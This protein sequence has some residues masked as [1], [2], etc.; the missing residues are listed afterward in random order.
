ML[1]AEYTKQ[2]KKD[3]KLA[4]KRNLPED[5]I[6]RVMSK[7]IKEEPLEPRYR[8]HVLSGDYKGFGECHVRPDWLLIYLKN[9]RAKTITFVRTGSHSDLFD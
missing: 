6:K 7:L 4:M 1:A 5:E 2:F 9:T 8:D 3:Y